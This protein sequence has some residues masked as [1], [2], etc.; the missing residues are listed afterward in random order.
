MTFQGKTQMILDKLKETN[1][2]I[3]KGDKDATY[4]FME[5]T[6]SAFPDYANTII[7]EQIMLPIWR[8]TCDT[9]EYQENVQ[10]IDTRRKNAHGE[11]NDEI[12]DIENGIGGPLAAFLK[13]GNAA[14][15]A[16]VRHKGKGVSRGDRCRIHDINE[17]VTAG[18]YAY[19][20][21]APVPCR[22]ALVQLP[23]AKD[24][25]GR[26]S[27]VSTV[28]LCRRTSHGSKQQQCSHPTNFLSSEHIRQPLKP[29][30]SILN[31][32]LQRWNFSSVLQNNLH[33]RP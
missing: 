30:P 33:P 29:N 22:S 10:A 5:R 19:A 28:G 26:E 31:C 32:K 24:G 3:F 23:H 4:K 1:Y 8:N 17:P 6:L 18:S 12:I 7:R 21:H 16:Q 25:V 2:E 27:A 15:Q 9:N 20:T 14:V 13:N 11:G